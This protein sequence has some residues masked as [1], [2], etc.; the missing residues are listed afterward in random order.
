MLR[1]EADMYAL[2]ADTEGLDLTDLFENIKFTKKDMLEL[3]GIYYITYKN[4]NAENAVKFLIPA[5]II[6][7]LLK[8]YNEVKEHYFQNNKETMFLEVQKQEDL[9]KK[10][11]EENGVLKEKIKNLELQIR[12][13]QKEAESKYIERI[14]A[15]EK[16]IQ[17]MK[18]EMDI[19]QQNE[20]ELFAL[21]EL[22]FSLDRQETY[23]PV[24]EESIDLSKIKGVL[25]GGQE[26]WH[27]RMREHLL[28]FTFVNTENF[29]VKLLDSTD[30]VI[31]FP[32]FLNHKLYYKV[33]NEVRKKK[34]PVG[35]IAS[36]NEDLAL[37]QIK[38]I[39][40]RYLQP[41]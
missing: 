31:I 25:I 28:L 13:L 27:K 23:I 35:Y 29:D 33:I 16:E 19:L 4:L 1:E 15:L 17:D 40:L 18:K 10:L 8:A 34:I 3:L 12:T 24:E 36:L 37:E 11:E 2:I 21:R 32:N 26:Q 14:R 6:K 41:S 7:S 20:K 30:I 5:V 9:I 22:M 38:E 39:V